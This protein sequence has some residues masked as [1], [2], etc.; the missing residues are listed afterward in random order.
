MSVAA[1]DVDAIV[2]G[3]GISGLTAA[4]ELRR[5]GAS[6]LVLEARDR[7]GGKMHTVEIEG[8]PVDLGAHW[9][10]PSQRRIGALARELGIE[11]EP[12]YLE[13]QHLLTLGDRRHTFTGAIPLTSPLGVAET[14]AAAAR[15]EVR[16][17]LIDAHAPWRSRGARRLDAQTLGHWARDLR[18]PT[19]RAT[20]KI[21]ARTVFGAEPSEISF[22]YF[23]WY[24]QVAG[25][26]R[27]VTEFE[28]AAQ[29]ARLS[30]GAQ[31]VCERLASELG[32]ALTPASPV[33]SIEES[34]DLVVVRSERREATARRVIVAIAPALTAGIAFD[35]PLPP[36]REAL[37]Q[38]MPMGTYMKGVAVYER[39][40]WRDRGL[41]GLAFAD[42]GPVQMVVDDSPPGGRPGV[43]VAF[44]TGAPARELGRR[45]PDARRR[46]VVDAVTRLFGPDAARPAAY[47]DLNWVEE[48]WSRGGP[49]GVMAPGA[50]TTVGPA[51]REPAGRVH[52]AGTETATEWSGYMDGGVQAGERAAREVLAAMRAAP[53]GR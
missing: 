53:P 31:Q 45:D 30:G 25:G 7:V 39:A 50:L 46:A 23:L 1:S 10:G 40:W 15:I 21:V 38:R 27:P 9:V 14:A 22:L 44:V 35:P 36:A 5:A 24:V 3:A 51:L 8:A 18:T 43:L 48:P 52:W 26:Y 49:V 28:G 13:G 12:Q 41:S 2:V 4:R 6:V 19:A 16:R 34:G 29:D 17:R 33:Q 47:R 42:R 37:G 20:F 11:S 32:D